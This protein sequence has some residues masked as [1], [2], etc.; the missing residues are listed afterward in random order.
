MPSDLRYEPTGLE[1]AEPLAARAAGAG[2]DDF[3]LAR[4]GNV[5]LISSAKPKTAW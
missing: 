4:T 2:D 3:G 1:S 5:R